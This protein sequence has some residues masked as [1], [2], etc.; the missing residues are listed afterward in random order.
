MTSKTLHFPHGEIDEALWAAY[1]REDKA[2]VMDYL[3][4]RTLVRISRS[5][6]FPQLVINPGPKRGFA[7]NRVRCESM[8]INGGSSQLAA[9]YIR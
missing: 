8:R 9:R 5:T 1:R 2:A 7:V 4:R 6:S 3:F